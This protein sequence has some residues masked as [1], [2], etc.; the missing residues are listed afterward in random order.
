[1]EHVNEKAE[2]KT[3]QACSHDRSID[4]WRSAAILKVLGVT[5]EDI[6]ELCD[7]VINCQSQSATELTQE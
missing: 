3:L 4:R 6:V 2:E 5:A 1:M 7:Y